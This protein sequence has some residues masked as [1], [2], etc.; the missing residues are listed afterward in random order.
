M[1]SRPIIPALPDLESSA[2]L[3]N[4]AFTHEEPAGQ[5]GRALVLDL[6]GARV[7]TAGVLGQLVALNNRLRASGGRLV[8]CNVP[9]GAF[10]VFELTNL[11]E[12]LDVRRECLPRPRP[13][14]EP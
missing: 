7:P 3:M 13:I 5:G 12:L 2:R 14:P 4:R 10:E 8:L 6:T 1:P 9:P 11:T